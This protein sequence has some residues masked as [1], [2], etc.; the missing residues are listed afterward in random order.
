MLKKKT[1]ERMSAKKA[2]EHPWIANCTPSKMSS[3]SN[4][5]EILERIQK[6]R[7]FIS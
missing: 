7:V 5:E 4:K 2:L 1:K 6:F 3:I